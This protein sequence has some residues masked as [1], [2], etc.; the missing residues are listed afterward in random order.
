MENAAKALDFL[1]AAS[2]RDQLSA[3]QERM[4]KEFE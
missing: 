4:E 1:E 3:L 2:L